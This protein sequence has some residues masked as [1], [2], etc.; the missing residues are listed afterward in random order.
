[1]PIYEYKAIDSAK[2]CDFCANGFDRFQP[3]DSAPTRNCPRCG[4]PIA[5]QI[6]HVAIGRSRSSLDHRAKAA[7]FT[8][9]K[10]LGRGEYERQY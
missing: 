5:K 8:K 7:G 1:M 9:L 4:A 2:S 3:L 6:P 10:K